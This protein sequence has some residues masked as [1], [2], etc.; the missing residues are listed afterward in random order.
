[1][2]VIPINV[3]VDGRMGSNTTAVGGETFVM[4]AAAAGGWTTE[5]DTNKS[6][7]MDEKDS[8]ENPGEEEAPNSTST[9]HT[10]RLVDAVEKAARKL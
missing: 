9:R 3:V 5:K 10:D 8:A 2:T 1:M 4:G 7:G 6:D